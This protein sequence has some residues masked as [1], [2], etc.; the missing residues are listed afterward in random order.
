MN[1]RVGTSPEVLD[2]CPTEL[3][4]LYGHDQQQHQ[5]PRGCGSDPALEAE[6]EQPS[7]LSSRPS[8]EEN[9][10]D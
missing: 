9:P 7:T 5:L 6:Q 3:S 1:S 10:R 2:L 8:P 4:R